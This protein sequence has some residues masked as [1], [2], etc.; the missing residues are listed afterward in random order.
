MMTNI[1][2]MRDFLD[3][4]ASSRVSKIE[5]E[6]TA[7]HVY[8]IHRHIQTLGEQGFTA[9]TTPSLDCVFIGREGWQIEAISPSVAPEHDGWRVKSPEDYAALRTGLL[10][11][12]NFGYME[13]QSVHRPDMMAIMFKHVTKINLQVV[14]RQTSIY[15]RVEVS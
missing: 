6:H 13:D 3:V 9:F 7:M 5:H 8:G 2:F 1:H 10:N 12:Q 4:L 11:H 14:W 15:P